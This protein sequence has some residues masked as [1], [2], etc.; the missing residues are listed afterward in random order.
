[1]SGACA[2]NPGQV[3]I[4]APLRTESVPPNHIGPGHRSSTPYPHAG[5]RLQ[6]PAELPGHQAV[7]IAL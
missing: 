4:K 7:D 1:M 2:D 3:R 5:P 6:P